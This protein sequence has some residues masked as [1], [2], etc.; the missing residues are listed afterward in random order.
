MFWRIVMHNQLNRIFLKLFAYTSLI[1]L[2][3]RT[4]ILLAN[5]P[6]ATIGRLHPEKHAFINNDT[7]LRV[8]PTHIEIVRTNTGEVIDEFGNLDFYSGRDVAISPNASHVSVHNNTN[9]PER[10]TVNIWDVNSREKIIEWE[11]EGYIDTVAIS[12]T[13]SMLA[14]SIDNEIYLWNMQTGEKIG[15]MLGDRR[16]SDTCYYVDGRWRTCLSPA[17]DFASV[18]TPDGRYLI[19]A[20]QRPDIELWNIE[21]LEL[22][23]HF[24]GHTGNWVNGVIISLD[25]EYLAS[26]DREQPTVYLW[27]MNTR[28]LMWKTQTDRRSIFDLEFSPDSQ[29]LY[30]ARSDVVERWNVKSGELIDTFNTEFRWLQ[31]ITISPDG[32]KALLMY[33]DGEI[34]WDIE[35]KKILNEWTD[36][37]TYWYKN[38]IELSPDGKTVLAMSP[39]T[40]K[41]FDVSSQNMR[42]L[43]STQDNILNTIAISPDSKK[44]AVGREPIVEIRNIQTGEIET[45]FPHHI[46][47]PEKICFSPSGRWLAVKDHW[48]H[49]EIL[50]IDSPEKKQRL[51]SPVNLGSRNGTYS[52][53]FSDNEEYFVTSGSTKISNNNYKYWIVLWKRVEDTFA[54]KYAW[55]GG[56]ASDPIFMTDADGSTLLAGNGREGI[57]IWKLLED[58]PFLLSSFDA[59]Y[60][61]QFSEDGRYLFAY[62]E[63]KFQI[64]DWRRSK[65][66]NQKSFPWFISMSHDSS[67]LLTHGIHG[68]YLIWDLTHMQSFLPYSVEPNGKQ[69]VTLGQIKRN[70]LLQNFPN[71]F[72]PETW[73]PFKLADESTVTIDIHSST[74]KLIRSISPGTMKAGDYSTQTQAVHW[75][76]K[77][78]DGEPVSSGIFFYTINA[79]DFS[80]TRKMLIKK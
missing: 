11:V 28:E 56:F 5:E 31:T 36:F 24:E 32:K 79:G 41:S 20:S 29:N 40:I 3:C 52:I 2:L 42:L 75:D 10:D 30:V 37:I 34:L 22:E 6:I 68:Q 12:P 71:P 15:T 7:I 26:Y 19:V 67:L 66:I 62:S 1:L 46:L 27:N 55:L 51:D 17:S 16:P 60:P 4:D 78:K 49:V 43:I 21:T 23:G 61:L 39:L 64:W 48:N 35:N 33:Q 9:N 14:T 38:E 70:Q 8:V 25:G 72:N 57:H 73:I 77:N 44:F 65:L 58:K 74:G 13:Q 53:G 18:F 63:D 76:G 50:D 45:Q 59:E 80:A 47:L 54:Y 69:F